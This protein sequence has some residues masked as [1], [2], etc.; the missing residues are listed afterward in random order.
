MSYF[1]LF[2]SYFSLQKTLL[3]I[4][5]PVSFYSPFAKLKKEKKIHA[6]VANNRQEEKPKEMNEV[7][8]Q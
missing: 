4:C 8:S 3:C 6:A 2:S 5:L 1:Y 7:P